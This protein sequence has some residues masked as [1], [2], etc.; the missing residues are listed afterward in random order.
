MHAAVAFRLSCKLDVMM[1]AHDWM[2]VIQNEKASPAIQLGHSKATL[3]LQIAI[4][5]YVPSSQ[6]R[7]EIAQPLLHA[8]PLPLQRRC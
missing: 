6:S 5:A 1:S 2:L 8:K 4:R 7:Q 3:P